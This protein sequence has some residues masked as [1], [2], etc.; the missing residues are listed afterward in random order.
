MTLDK[1]QDLKAL[2]HD[3]QIPDVDL[4][5]EVMRKL[6]AERN[7]KERFFV[8]YKV[9]MLVV[10]GMLLTV[11]SGFA[12][13]KYGVLKNEQGQAVYEVKPLKSAP[14]QTKYS[15]EDTQ[16]IGMSQDLAEELLPDGSAAIFYIV[17]NNPNK[18]TD[19]RF[20]PFVFNDL[21]ALRAKMA[22][23]PITILDRLQENYKFEN[24]K[25]FFQPVDK[26][27]P[28][29]PDEKAAT[30]EKLRKQAEE[31]GKDYAMMPIELSD[32][33]LHLRTV[34]KQ[35]DQ[36]VAVTV[37]KSNNGPF[38]AYIDEKIDF[39]QEKITVKGVEMLYTEYKDKDGKGGRKN[40]TWNNGIS[41]SEYTY[42]IDE[43]ANMSKEDLVKIAEAY[44][45]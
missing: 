42:Q 5:G 39:D 11:S 7:K 28:P 43:S 33:L 9:S 8:K 13:V 34:Y 4:T 10:A 17:P 18:Q 45:N 37:I 29:T 15:E 14:P 40:I 21:S 25:V 38:T 35:G 19:T 6:Y 24:A 16:R 31:S 1:D 30:A 2:F 41:G 20:K 44:L 36:E 22:G 23:K 12:A 27:N 26:V 3:P 32:D